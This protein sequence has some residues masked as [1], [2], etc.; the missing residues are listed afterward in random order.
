MNPTRLSIVMFSAML[1]HG[2]GR[3]TWLSNIL[4]ELIALRAFDLIDVH[5]V[6]DA[7]TDTHDKLKIC[8]DPRINFFEIRLPVSDSKLTSV[9]R[10]AIF[11]FQVVRRLRRVPAS[12][13]CVVAVGTFYEGAVLA[14]LKLFSRHPPKLVTWIRGVWSKEINHRHGN[15][16]K[17]L[18]C[19]SEKLFM[20]CSDHIISNGHDTKQFYEALLGR[21]VEAIPNALDLKKFAETARPAFQE[22]SKIIAYI[23]R[24]SEEKGF[25]SFLDAVATYFVAHTSSK[26]TFEIVGDGPLRVLAEDFV[27]A[28]PGRSVRYLGPISNEQIP[29]YLSTIDAGV[30]LTYSKASGGGGVSNAMLELI[31]AGRLVIAWD[32]PIYKQVLDDQQALFVDECNVA[33]LANSFARIDSDPLEMCRLI[34]CSGQVLS[35]YSMESHVKHFINYVLN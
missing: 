20:R 23:G 7:V 4:P 25:R 28:Y 6:A 17:Q 10:I 16:F 12:G 14:L 18:I 9:R 31:G 33:E 26:L 29:G 5:Y 22:E 34:K 13:H 8:A 15:F 21:H 30:N 2:G 1:S 32:S 27:A 24:L 19:S 11:C 3:E 35:Q